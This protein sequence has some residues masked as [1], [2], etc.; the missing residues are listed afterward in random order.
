MSEPVLKPRPAILIAADEAIAACWAAVDAISGEYG[1]DAD[2]GLHEEED[3]TEEM[4][5]R[6]PAARPS[7]LRSRHR[8][9]ILLPEHEH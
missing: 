9:G 7:A 1:L 6:I 4:P 3:P 8:A 5:R 2:S